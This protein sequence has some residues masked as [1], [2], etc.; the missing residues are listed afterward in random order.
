MPQSPE[1]L[2]E[3][4]ALPNSGLLVIR[5]PYSVSAEIARQIVARMDKVLAERGIALPVVIAEPGVDFETLSD[6]HLADVGLM[7]IP[8]T[9]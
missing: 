2:L 6:A 1:A 3:T 7:R 9:E 5:I 8:Q 4:V